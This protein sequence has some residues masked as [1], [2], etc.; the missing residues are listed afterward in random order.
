MW[1]INSE[2]EGKATGLL[3]IR[4][5]LRVEK[6]HVLMFLGNDNGILA[7]GGHVNCVVQCRVREI[8]AHAMAMVRRISVLVRFIGRYLLVYQEL[9]RVTNL[10]DTIMVTRDDRRL[11]DLHQETLAST[12]DNRMTATVKTVLIVKAR[13]RKAGHRI[14]NVVTGMETLLDL[15]VDD[16]VAIELEEPGGGL[17]IRRVVR[18][19]HAAKVLRRVRENVSAHLFARSYWAT[20][21]LR[22]ISVIIIANR[23]SG[24]LAIFFLR[25]FHA[26]YRLPIIEARDRV[27]MTATL[28]LDGLNVTLRLFP[29]PLTALMRLRKV[30]AGDPLVI[31][32]IRVRVS[33]K[34][35]V[36][37]DRHM[38]LIIPNGLL[39]FL[40]VSACQTHVHNTIANN[41]KAIRQYR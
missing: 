33:S 21:R 12:G 32:S 11:E 15:N 22:T 23:L 18:L 41:G 9:Q 10:M 13:E 35:I 34:T 25:R 1:T 28:L 7:H 29:H 36:G 8:V 31:L 5:T 16:N 2:K 27:K 26:I 20:R 19:V 3:E 40:R 17:T 14:H 38:R 4:T 37:D 6:D 39:K 24:R 30:I